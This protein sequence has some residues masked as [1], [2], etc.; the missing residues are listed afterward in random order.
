MNQKVFIGNYSKGIKKFELNEEGNL[1]YLTTI[2]D[3][4]NNSYIAKYKDHIYSVL[5]TKNGEVVAYSNGK[6]SSKQECGEL[7]CF[8]EIDEKKK[9]IYIANYLSGSFVVY[10]LEENGEIGRLLY[11][12]EYGENSNIHYIKAVEDKLYVIN[13]GQD[14]LYEYCVNYNNEKLEINEKNKIVFPKKTE[15]RHMVLDNDKNIFVVTEKSCELYKI[16]HD[17][18]EKL[19]IADKKSIIRPGTIKSDKDTGCAIKMDL[20]KEYIYVSVRGKNCISVFETESMNLIQNINCGGDCPRDIS[21]DITGK[22]FMCANQLSNNIAIYT[23][24]D[25]GILRYKD[26]IDTISPSCIIFDEV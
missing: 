5:E 25:D 16:I 26:N 22:F 4:D 7:P 11:S 17:D 21:F 9:I 19:K 3:L 14:T 20:D 6:V 18:K 8:L 12:R 15:P 2:G 1:K 24:L 23:V 10:K 13:L